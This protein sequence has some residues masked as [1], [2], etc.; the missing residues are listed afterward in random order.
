MT[1]GI[2]IAI[3]LEAVLMGIL[4]ILGLVE[5]ILYKDWLL[6]YHKDCKAQVV[7]RPEDVCKEHTLVDDEGKAHCDFIN[8]PYAKACY[9]KNGNKTG[10]YL[11]DLG[12]PYLKNNKRGN[13]NGN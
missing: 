7:F 3:T 10:W 1:T 5:L 8:C 12:Y 9:D 6:A 11:C 2:I 4:F 13:N